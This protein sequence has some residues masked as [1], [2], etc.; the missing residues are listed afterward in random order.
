LML[1]VTLTLTATSCAYERPARVADDAAQ[2]DAAIVGDA[3]PGSPVVEVALIPARVAVNDTV[4]MILTLHGNPSSTIA[5]AITTGGGSFA[6]SSGHTSTTADGFG[7]ITV[8]YTA[9]QIAGDLV[10]MLDMTDVATSHTPFQTKVRDLI[11]FGQ[12]TP[13]SDNQGQT[14]AP[15]YLYGQMVVLPSDY[16]VM[17]V[18]LIS[19]AGGYKARMAVYTDSAGVP[20]N[21]VVGSSSLQG[22]SAGTN[23]FKVTPALAV[24]GTYWV[25][26]NSDSAAPINESPTTNNSQAFVPLQTTAELPTEITGATVAAGRIR[27]FY[28]L[29]AM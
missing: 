12:N 24:A 15:N 8:N 4:A 6:P 13:F 23:E 14:I 19:Q 1:A 21:L 18:D 29:V 5:W 20:A 27:N 11:P 28:I 10:H 17:R 2:L 22:T 9:P 25:M 3:T 7:T 16:Y 26:V